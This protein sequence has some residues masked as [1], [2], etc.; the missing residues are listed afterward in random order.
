MSAGTATNV[1]TGK[2]GIDG[3]IYAAPIGTTLPV[4]ATEALN[5]AFKNLG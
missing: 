4:T 1:T 2:R 3:G 5:A